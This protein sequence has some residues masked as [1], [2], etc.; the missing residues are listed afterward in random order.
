MRETW[1]VD[2]V[3][4]RLVVVGIVRRLMV[5]LLSLFY[6]PDMDIGSVHICE[7]QEHP[8]TEMCNKVAHDHFSVT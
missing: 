5:E 3:I 6:P 2:S 4:K 7:A 1:V 8:S